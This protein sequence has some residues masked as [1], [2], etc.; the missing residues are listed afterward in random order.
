MHQA[1]KVHKGDLT[2]NLL[3]NFGKKVN[4]GFLKG[5]S[6]EKSYALRGDFEGESLFT[7]PKFPLDLGIFGMKMQNVHSC[8]TFERD[9]VQAFC[10][11]LC[12]NK[13]PQG[14]I[15]FDFCNFDFIW[16]RKGKATI[17]WIWLNFDLAGKVFRNPNHDDIPTGRSVHAAVLTQ[18]NCIVSTGRRRKAHI[19]RTRNGG[20]A[21]VAV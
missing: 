20:V 5:F 14:V 12:P 6:F 13:S 2:L 7:F 16:N 21:I 18:R 9:L 15:D 3:G 4:S 17:I 8:L 19:C 10:R 11:C 1:F